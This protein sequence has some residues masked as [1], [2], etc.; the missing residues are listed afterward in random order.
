MNCKDQI[1]KH[2]QEAYNKT[3]WPFFG[4]ASLTFRFGSETRNALNDL[5]NEGKVRARDSIRGKICEL[6]IN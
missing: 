2:M 4:M 3:G 5:S 6:I 1:L